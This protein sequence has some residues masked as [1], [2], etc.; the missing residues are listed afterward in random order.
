MLAFLGT[1][2][3]TGVRIRL[4]GTEHGHVERVVECRGW[5]PGHYV[6]LNARYLLQAVECLRC[7][8]VTLAIKDEASPMHIV[9][10]ELCVVLSPLRIS[11]P[12]D[13]QKDKK[14]GDVPEPSDEPTRV[15]QVE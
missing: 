13:C 12:T 1:R 15:P 14:K 8:E 9:D 10:A 2:L 4:E 7:E 3:P 5:Q 6:G 11:E